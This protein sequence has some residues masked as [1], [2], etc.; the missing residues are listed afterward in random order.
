M[1]PTYL[2]LQSIRSAHNVGAILRT[3]DGAGVSKVYLCGYTPAPI[4]RFGRMR[5]DIGKVAL[6]AEDTV[7]WE[8]VT[9]ITALIHD[10]KREG[11]RIVALE[12][13]ERSVPYT[14][15][16]LDQPTAIILGEEVKGIPPSILDLCDLIV[17]I[18]MCGTKE[19][20]N[21]SV[22]AGVLLFSYHRDSTTV[23]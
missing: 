19:S 23:R 12:Q 6:G 2:I 10:L 20:L 11:V 16:T 3:A 21:V 15:L 4:D 22:A 7:P 17:E 8:Q 9:D 1:P 18:P 14:S 5:R 13:D